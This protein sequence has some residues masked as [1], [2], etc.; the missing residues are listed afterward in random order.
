MIEAVSMEIH[1]SAGPSLRTALVSMPFAS[2]KRPSIQLGLLSSI[3]EAAGFPCDTFHLNLELASELSPEIYEKLCE[4]RGQMTGD[5]LFSVAAF[6]ESAACEPDRYFEAFPD[7]ETW[8]RSIGKDKAFLME[9]RSQVLPR[10]VERC[11]SVIDW[12]RYQLVGFTST[13]QQNAASLALARVIKDRFPSVCIVFGGANLEG[14]MGLELLRAFPQVDLVVS[15]EGDEAFPTLLR[16]LDQGGSVEHVRGVITRRA[17]GTVT[18]EQALPLERLDDLPIPRYDEYFRRA[19]ALGLLPSLGPGMNIPF[20][21]SRGCWWGAKQHCTFCGLNG[22]GMGFRKKTPSRLIE[23]LTQ[24]SARHVVT[25]F[26]AVD[27]ILSPDYIDLFFN[28]I[29]ER[30]L[31]FRFFYEVK[32][33][34]TRDKIRRLAHGGVRQVQPGIESLSTN[35]LKLMRKGCTMLQNVL[36]LKWCHYYGIQVSWNL[37]VGFPGE[38]AQDYAT[39]LHALKLISHLEPPTSC[40]RIWLERFSPNY[41]D[42][43]SVGVRNRRPSYSYS[44]VYPEYVNIDRIA[45]FFDYE[46]PD[47]LPDSAHGETRSLIEAWNEQWTSSQRHKLTYRRTPDMLLIDY[48]RGPCKRGTYRLVGS[49][50]MAYEFCSET[51]RNPRSVQIH[52]SE[53]CSENYSVEEVRETLAGF[54]EAG[55]MLHED[56]RFLGLAL[57]A[58]RNH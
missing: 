10:F 43:E 33:N 45:Y 35:V 31:D 49:V 21:S 30:R 15:G 37:L 50:A 23:E 53:Q 13:F 36:C 17:D 3:A 58:N 24:L 6:K 40:G 11:G 1:T 55:L 4:H 16:V 2:S 52:L 28:D 26:E 44:F 20:E 34:L 19:E 48:E 54:C 51:M 18:G 8:I 41:V 46:M 38:T 42:G 56:D 9:L 57:P 12:G 39:Q 14:E 27:N 7:E 47:A 32:S 29:A 5:W 22:V 25:S